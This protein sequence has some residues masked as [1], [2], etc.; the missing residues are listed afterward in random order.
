MNADFIFGLGVLGGIILVLGAMWPAKKVQIPRNSVKNQLFAA[1]AI[2]LFTYAVLNYLYGTG[3]LFFAI[4]EVLAIVSSALMLLGISEKISTRII[5]VLGIGLVIWSIFIA[6]D[7]FAAIFILGLIMVSWGYILESGTTKRN[8]LLAVGSLLIAF[9]SYLGSAWVFFW[10]N[11]FFAGF[12][13]YHV[14]ELS[15]QSKN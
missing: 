11:I 12:S 3:T 4:L 15:K 10:L 9:F 13:F 5:S 7:Y 14:W 1:G 8:L 2:I 6:K